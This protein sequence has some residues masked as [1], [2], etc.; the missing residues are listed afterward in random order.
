MWLRV[1]TCGY[2]W[3]RVKWTRSSMPSFLS[4]REGGEEVSVP[5]VWSR[6]ARLRVRWRGGEIRS[7]LQHDGAEIRSEDLGIGLL[8][9]L[10][11]ERLL[12][13]QPEPGGEGRCEMWLRVMWLRGGDAS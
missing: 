5:G 9:Q 3:L 2:M 6:R 12:R 8:H 11:L 7:H 4:C 10:L 13:V 1:V